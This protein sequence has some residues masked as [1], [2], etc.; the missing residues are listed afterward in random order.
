[1]DEETRR[2]APRGAARTPDAG[3]REVWRAK[4][5]GLAG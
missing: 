5:V 4:G 1:M 2:I 3:D